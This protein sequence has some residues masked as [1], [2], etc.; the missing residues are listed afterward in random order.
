[1]ASMQV[2]EML[3]KGSCSVRLQPDV[4]EWVRR[5]RDLGF[6]GL[7]VLT[8]LAHSTRAARIFAT[9]MKWFFPWAQ[10]NDRRGAKASM[11]M[12]A[13]MPV[14]RYSQPSARV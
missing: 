6:F 4:C 8:I 2:R 13:A 11:S 14:R 1:M 10:K 7:K 12:P 5:A 9:S 3:L